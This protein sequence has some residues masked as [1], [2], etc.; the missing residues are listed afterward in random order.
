MN[1]TEPAALSSISFPVPP[2]P[3]ETTVVHPSKIATFREVIDSLH[4]FS[5]QGLS[6]IRAFDAKIRGGASLSFQE[7]L[8]FQSLLGSVGL[9]VELLSKVAESASATTRRLQNGQ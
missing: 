2:R 7:L 5:S 9:R 6:E 4:S 3:I 8:S 1:I